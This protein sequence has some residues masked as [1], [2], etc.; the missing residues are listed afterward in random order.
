MCKTDTRSMG[1]E[2]L[3]WIQ[4]PQDW[5]NEEHCNEPFEFYKSREFLDQLSNYHCG[6]EKKLIQYSDCIKNSQINK[7]IL[8]Q[9]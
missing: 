9:T 1:C 6:W 8:N 4:L 3:E 5:C 7:S 2:I